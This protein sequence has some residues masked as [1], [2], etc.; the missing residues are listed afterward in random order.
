MTNTENQTINHLKANDYRDFFNVANNVLKNK[1]IKLPSG[2]IVFD[3][4]YNKKNNFKSVVYQKGN[5]IVIC[6]IG[7]DTLKIKDHGANLKMGLSSEPTSQMR[8]AFDFFK[9]IQIKNPD[10]EYKVIGHSEGGSEAIYVGLSNNIETVTFNAYGLNQKLADKIG[11]KNADNIITNYRNSQDPVSKMRNPQGKNYIVENNKDSFL[12]KVSPFGSIS[13]HKISNFGDCEKA[14]SEKEY[15]KTHKNFVNNIKE[16]V[17]TDKDIGKMSNELFQLYDTEISNRL[18]KGQ[19]LSE[20]QAKT[21]VVKGNLVHV[22]AY[23]RDD[24]VH[25]ESY[26]RRKPNE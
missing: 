4:M 9:E 15:S 22:S 19:I 26:Y 11:G 10:M 12:S 17:L 5:E 14:V 7:T 23:T 2:Y 1:N 21:E 24:G 16:I 18:S 20:N 25:I 13:A 8:D 6:Y 3:T